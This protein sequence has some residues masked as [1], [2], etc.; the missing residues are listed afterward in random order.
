MCNRKICPGIDECEVK[1]LKKGTNEA[2]TWSPSISCCTSRFSARTRT[3]LRLRQVKAGSRSARRTRSRWRAS[4]RNGYSR[5]DREND[6]G[7]YGG[8]DRGGY[9]GSDRGGYGGYDRTS[10]RIRIGPS[11]CGAFCVLPDQA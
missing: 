4:G 6:G 3:S 9:G 7:G 5:Y 10:R 11:V 2:T 1:Q 8:S